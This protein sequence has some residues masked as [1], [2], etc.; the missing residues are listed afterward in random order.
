MSNV[1]HL[2]A[3]TT[4][5]SLTSTLPIALQQAFGVA[6]GKTVTR[7]LPSTAVWEG[8]SDHGEPSDFDY[9]ANRLSANVAFPRIRTF[10]VSPQDTLVVV[11]PD[12]S[13]PDQ[14]LAGRINIVDQDSLIRTTTFAVQVALE[15]VQAAADRAEVAKNELHMVSYAEQIS[16]SFEELVYLREL[17]GFIEHCEFP[18]STIDV[19]E[20][21]LGSLKDLVRAETIVLIKSGDDS[22][23]ASDPQLEDNRLVITN[24]FGSD[25]IQD[26]TCIA[27]VDCFGEVADTPVVMNR[28]N[29]DAGMFELLGVRNIILLPVR[30]GDFQFG[31]LMVL[32][33]I[34]P[35]SLHDEDEEIGQDEF[36]TVE[37]GLLQA[38]TLLLATHAKNLSLFQENESL[39]LGAVMSLVQTLEARDLYTRGHSDRVADFAKIIA[40][41]MGLPADEVERIHLTGLLHDIGKIG[42]PDKILHKPDSLSDEEFAVIKQHP[43]I[44]YR[45]LQDL[46]SISYVLPGVL[47][48]HE[49][50]DGSGYPEGLKG[51]AIPLMARIL[52]VADGYDAMTSDRPYRKGMPT[53]KAESIIRENRGTQW[54]S[55]AVDAFFRRIDDIHE[56]VDCQENQP[57]TVDEVQADECLEPSV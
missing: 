37:A 12:A 38:T 10:S 41:E 40:T 54:D 43:V 36:G 7:H 23:N 49:S 31:W 4:A 42:I 35:E 19:A 6:F 21:M 17:T 56:L 3:A 13:E 11:T 15:R 44:G 57:V 52:A 30:R 27:L 9:E 14:H 34:P 51:D 24:R 22:D 48:H 8:Y 39:V 29:S 33:K 55:D 45:I 16:N 2:E 25:D 18:N 1:I 5:K 53:T 32:N 47:Y 50:V 28:F 26:S 20:A 46:A